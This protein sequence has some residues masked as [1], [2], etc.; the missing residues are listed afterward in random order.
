M[1]TDSAARP[2]AFRL[3]ACRPHGTPLLAPLYGMGPY[4]YRDNR[5]AIVVGH[6][7]ED[8]IRECLPEQLTPVDDTVVL[9]CFVCP[10]VTGIGPHSFTMP[11]IPVRHGDVVG[12]YVPYL[13]TSTEAS[14]ACYREVQGWPAVLGDTS[15]DVAHG[16][17]RARVVRHGRTL[18]TVEGHVGGEPVTEL[19]FLPVI[20]FKEIPSMDTASCDVAHFVISTSL[21][22]RLDLRAGTGMVRFPEPDGH[23][24]ARLAPHRVDAL[25]HGTLDDLYPETIRVLEEVG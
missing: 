13:F 23:P 10:D 4:Q 7:D 17:V 14:L 16:H 2:G 15:V 18:M 1:A 19:E 24:V 25:F 20:L 12:Q 22:E 8:A 11:L 5:V 21:F 6:A 9:C 3:S